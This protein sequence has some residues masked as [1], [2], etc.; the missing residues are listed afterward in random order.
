MST[1]AKK[2]YIMLRIKEIMKTK[3]VSGK[4]L[5]KRMGLSEAALSLGLKTSNPT[6]S[7]LQEYADA[8]SVP[9]TELF[10]APNNTISCPRCGAVIEFREK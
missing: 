8:L 3:G 1:F 4:E 9:I 6:L 10:D 7:R 2:F 5:A